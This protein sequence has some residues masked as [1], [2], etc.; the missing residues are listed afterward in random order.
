MS[1]LLS[2]NN[3]SAS[4]YE[5]LREHDEDSEGLDVEDI[6]GIAANGGHRRDSFSDQALR[7]L[8]PQT[9]TQGIRQDTPRGQ[10][11]NQLLRKDKSR[12]RNRPRRHGR[13]SKL[14][15]V[16]EA[17]DDV[18]ASLLIDHNA[19]EIDTDSMTLPPPPSS[20]PDPLLG[21]DTS[22]PSTARRFPSR[23]SPPSRSSG[24]TSSRARPVNGV[25]GAILASAD[26]KEK[27][28]FRWVNVT[29]LDNFLFEV[30]DYYLAHGFW[31]TLLK[32]FFDLLNIAFVLGFTIFLTQCIDYRAI[33]GSTKTSEIL[34][35][36]CTKNMGFIP[37]A[38]LWVATLIWLWNGV[39][40]IFDIPRL[41]H[42]HDFYLHLLDIP[43]QE[44]QSISWQEVVSR[45]MALRDSN[46]TITSKSTRGGGFV[47]TQ[48][49]QRMDAHDIA[50]RLMRKQNYMI[51]M[52]NKDV[53]DLTLPIP[54]LSNRKLYTRTLEWNIE[55]CIMEFIFN[56]KG[57]IR[58]LFLERHPPQRLGCGP[59]RPIHSR[60]LFKS[61]YCTVL[62]DIRGI[63]TLLR[64][65]QR[66][67]EEPRPDWHEGVHPFRAMEV[68]RVQ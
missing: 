36:Q 18:P 3:P 4:I 32:R 26:P 13:H 16:E 15:D 31:S 34:V 19:Q 8:S 51:A 35:P 57:Q 10:G 37:N 9:H 64:E 61:C 33:K 67:P 65:L 48:D 38:F 17:D 11:Q 39:L 56:R 25:V 68:S 22:D 14:L 49:K 40:C 23:R 42:M 30:Y 63:E 55:L 62:G 12:A 5:T 44:I 60:G 41:N 28:M 58:P 46:P 6:A 43:E 47:K 50:N 27:A 1:R 54:Y 24:Q 53:L 59:P 2:S 29:D 20:M 66:L 45:L 7:G 21:R 52:I